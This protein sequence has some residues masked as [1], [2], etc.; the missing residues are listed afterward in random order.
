[1]WKEA[2]TGLRLKGAVHDGAEDQA[3]A[4]GDIV[5]ANGN[6]GKVVSKEAWCRFS[7]YRS[8]DALD[9]KLKWSLARYLRSKL[10]AQG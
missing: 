2:D 8:H 7:G 5:G 9:G 10:A 6:L 3:A 1:M 4:C